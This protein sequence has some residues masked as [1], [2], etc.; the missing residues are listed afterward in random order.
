MWL[1]PI[2]E[3]APIAQR[4]ALSALRATRD[5][6]LEEGLDLEHRLYEDCLASE[7]RREA[8]AAFAEKRKPV[9]RGR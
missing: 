1:S 9:F 7:D 2:T 5:R 3:G 8:L 4:A 6:S